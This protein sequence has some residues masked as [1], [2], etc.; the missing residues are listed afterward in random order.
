MIGFIAGDAEFTLRDSETVGIGLGERVYGETSLD[1][2]MGVFHAI[3]RHQD[4]KAPKGDI[5]TL[6]GDIWDLIVKYDLIVDGAD[7]EENDQAINA[8]ILDI[9][10]LMEGE[11]NERA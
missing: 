11:K 5:T 10:C 1:D 2:L 9:I 3:R 4:G 8:F 7:G 6:R